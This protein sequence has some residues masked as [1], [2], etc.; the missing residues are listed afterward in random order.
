MLC[1]VDTLSIDESSVSFN[2][3]C[4]QDKVTSFISAHVQTA[5]LKAE[6]N[7]ELHYILPFDEAKK[8]GFEKLFMALDR[9]LNELNIA[10][11]GIAD[12]SLEEVFLRITETRPQHGTGTYTRTHTGT[13]RGTHTHTHR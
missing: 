8:G 11:Y 10:S 13:H 9:A 3:R 4:S 2:S 6:T 5:Y 7:H 12:T 1:A